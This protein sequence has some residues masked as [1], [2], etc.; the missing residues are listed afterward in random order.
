MCHFNLGIHGLNGAV[1]PFHK[2][3]LRV[4]GSLAFD[5]GVNPWH[6]L[7][8]SI[9]FTCRKDPSWSKLNLELSGH[10]LHV[11]LAFMIS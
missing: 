10:A 5:I 4:A 1:I 11:R 6:G 7:A 8:Q 3:N 2:Y 9:D